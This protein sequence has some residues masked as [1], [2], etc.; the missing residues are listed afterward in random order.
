[1]ACDL[2]D[3]AAHLRAVERRERDH[4]M[5]RAHRPGRAEFRP[6]GGD[7][8]QRGLGAALGEPGHEIERGRVGP[9]QILE[10]EHD[11]LVS[12]ARQNPGGHRRQLP[13]PQFLRRELR[14]T[15]LRQRN[16]DQRREQRRIFGRV[17]ADQRQSVLEVGE[18]HLVTRV[19][20]A[21]AESAPFGERVQGRVL[22]ELRGG[23]FDPGVRRLGK[24]CA[25]LLD[26]ARLADAGLAD[27]L[28]ELAFACERAQPAARQQR[29]L[30]LAADERR[31]GPRPAAAAA[32]ARAHDAIERQRR[33]RALEF[34]RAPVLDDEEARD[35]ALHARGDQHRSRLGQ[36][37]HP[38]RDIGRVAENLAGRIHHHR[39]CRNADSG[40]E[41]GARA[42]VLTVQLGQ[43]AL[44]REGRANGALGVVLLRDR[45]AE[46]RHDPV[47]ELLRDMP[48][49]LSDRRG[50]RVEIAPDQIAPVLGVERCR[51]A[52]RADQIAE[53]DREMAAF[54]V[55]LERRARRRRPGRQGGGLFRRFGRCGEGGDRLEKLLAVAQG[56]DAEIL[57]IIVRQRAQQL[58]VDVVGAEILGVLAE[59]DPAKPTVDVQVQ[60]PDLRSAAVLEKAR[61]I[62]A[63]RFQPGF[64]ISPLTQ[65]RQHTRAVVRRQ[66][67]FTVL[68]AMIAGLQRLMPVG[69]V[70][71]HANAT[72]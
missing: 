47:A 56:R 21:K 57:E 36:R 8:Q 17:E 55:G 41:L 64:A 13:A 37:L 39:P 6:R 24:S 49:H 40:G 15:V 12:S 30:V 18:T 46:Q 70:A 53:Q 27:D 20:A 26:Q 4:A 34:V 9:M 35:L 72:S 14:P 42:G 59:T 38:G 7:D 29:D 10:G 44:D 48:A 62:G 43:R 51:E 28:D 45:K 54:G 1:M 61:A 5:V 33:G 2:A 66:T 22:Q 3:H 19:G 31:Q 63:A 52:G 60:P 25:E 71:R 50:R 11:R 67:D 65:R 23:P 69:L 32:A 16:V 68:L 58:A